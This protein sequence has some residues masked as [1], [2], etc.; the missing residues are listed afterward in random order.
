MRTPSR[1]RLPA[2]RSPRSP[3]ARADAA[4]P[5]VPWGKTSA[6]L[7][8]AALN[9]SGLESPL[10]V[11]P[12]QTRAIPGTPAPTTQHNLTFW[13]RESTNHSSPMKL[14]AMSTSPLYSRIWYF[15]SRRKGKHKCGIDRRRPSALPWFKP[16]LP[17]NS[18][19]QLTTET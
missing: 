4:P 2:L 9:I 12:L 7:A 11:C 15:W 5:S 19:A 8:H 16:Y 14:Q 17:G 1:S 13:L 10:Q 3:L 18:E 6:I